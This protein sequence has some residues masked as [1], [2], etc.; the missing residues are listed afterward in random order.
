MDDKNVIQTLQ[1]IERSIVRY[2]YIQIMVTFIKLGLMTPE[3]FRQQAKIMMQLQGF[4]CDEEFWTREFYD[5]PREYYEPLNK[6]EEDMTKIMKRNVIEL[7][8]QGKPTYE[9][10]QICG[11]VEADVVHILENAGLLH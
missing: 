7:Y 4:K 9:I 5:D 1:K 2:S 10:A 6:E 8:H 11:I 3:E